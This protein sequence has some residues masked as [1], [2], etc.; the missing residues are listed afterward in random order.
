LLSR[1]PTGALQALELESRA[2][3][4]STPVQVSCLS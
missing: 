1:A 4:W 2:A 3:L